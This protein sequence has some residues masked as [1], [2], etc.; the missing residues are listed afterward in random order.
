MIN[1]CSIRTLKTK[2]RPISLPDTSDVILRTDLQQK[3]TAKELTV[4][5]YLYLSIITS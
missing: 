2:T 4:F 5:K 3:K 1:E